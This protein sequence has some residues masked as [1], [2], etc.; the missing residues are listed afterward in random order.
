MKTD[1]VN[2]LETC[3]KVLEQGGTVEECLLRFPAFAD[4]LRP[5]LEQSI[6]ARRPGRSPIPASVVTA[7]RVRVLNRAAQFRQNKQP[8]MRDLRS[9][10]FAAI[11]LLVLVLFF[12]TGN[13][14]LA[15]SARSLPGDA[16]YPLKR[17]VE[18]I[19][20]FLAPTSH[21]KTEILKIISTRRITETESLLSKKRVEAVEFGGQVSKQLADG[22]TIAGIHVQVTGETQMEAALAPGTRVHV[23]GQT[24]LDGSVLAAEVKVENDKN[25]NEDNP[26]ESSGGE[27]TQEPEITN[28]RAPGAEGGDEANTPE[29][30]DKMMIKDIHLPDVRWIS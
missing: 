30:A 20:L 28:D 24:Q 9:W 3:L 17:S 11:P 13:G 16:L 19:S 7:G 29:P 26:S 4:D 5:L 27:G 21:I 25:E 8:L 22:W 6:V 14:F 1:L 18:G 2:A 15:V 12:I 23:R 10:R